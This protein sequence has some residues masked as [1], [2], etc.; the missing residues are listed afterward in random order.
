MSTIIRKQF[1]F[2]LGHIVRKA[3]SERCKKSF[4]GHSYVCEVMMTSNNPDSGFMATDFGFTKKYLHPF[5]DS[6]DHA[7]WWWDLEEDKESIDLF[8]E[9]F[10]RVIVTPWST[11]AEVQAQMFYYYAEMVFKYLNTNKAWENGEGLVTVSSVKVHET[12]TGWAEASSSG[13][14]GWPIIR[15][16][17][18]EISE[19]I[20]DEWPEKFRS[21]WNDLLVFE[22][23]H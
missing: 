1:K 22:K 15:L 6:F 12:T 19:P 7:S 23:T 4:H 8:R 10:A 5:I 16:N 21:F 17:D 11:T 9:K 2:E 3:W 20:M 14:N 13:I 18:M